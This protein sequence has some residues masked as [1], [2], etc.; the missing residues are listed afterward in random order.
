[1]KKKQQIKQLNQLAVKTQEINSLHPYKRE[2]AFLKASKEI[3]GLYAGCYDTL[4][5]QAKHTANM[6][7][8]LDPTVRKWDDLEVGDLFEIGAARGKFEVV[9]IGH[10]ACILENVLDEGDW[11]FFTKKTYIDSR[12]LG[13]VRDEVT[14]EDDL[15]GCLTISG[16]ETPNIKVNRYDYGDFLVTTIGVELEPTEETKEFREKLKESLCREEV[17]KFWEQPIKR[18]AWIN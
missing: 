15:G 17:R 6:M 12:Y 1:M 7:K 10:C 11:T 8:S 3:G 5:E 9:E 2:E 13:N 4:A 16:D 14:T 18:I